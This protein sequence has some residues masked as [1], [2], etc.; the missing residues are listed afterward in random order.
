MS[1]RMHVLCHFFQKSKKNAKP[2]A[3]EWVLILFGQHFGEKIYGFG[4][5]KKNAAFSQIA[6]VRKKKTKRN[7]INSRERT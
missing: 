1:K 7:I 4:L 6:K 5:A 2:D 3:N